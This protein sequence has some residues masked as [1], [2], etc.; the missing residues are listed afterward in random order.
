[1]KSKDK[2]DSEIER[3]DFFLLW[4]N[5][6]SKE[7]NSSSRALTGRCALGAANG[8]SSK[9]MAKVLREEVNLYSFKNFQVWK[10]GVT[11]KMHS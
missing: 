4:N 9:N 11:L 8:N 3:C 6:F 1:M 7:T 2:N 10:L 5:A